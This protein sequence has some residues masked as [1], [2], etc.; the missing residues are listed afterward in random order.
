MLDNFFLT[1]LAT[2]LAGISSLS[3]QVQ[4]GASSSSWLSVDIIAAVQDTDIVGLLCLITLAIFSIASWGI[5]GYKLLHVNQATRQT[6]EFV[7]HCMEG[8]GNLEEAYKYAGNFP[9]SP[10]AQIM[11]D[12]Y[13][14]L[15][16]ENWYKDLIDLGTESR[17]MA[18]R[19]GAERVIERSIANEIKHL[20]GFLIFL[21]T[22]AAVCPF[23]GLFGT[24]WGVM[25]AFQE[26]ATSGAADITR[27]APG[28]S[29]ALTT[30]IAG[31]TAAIPAVISYNYLTTRVNG[32]LTRMDSFGLELMNI[33]QKQI[34]QK[35]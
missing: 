6:N 18:A 3:F 20:E 2:F 8:G 10:L 5:M 24:V 34:I 33:I 11:R 32:L 13:L 31:L 19:A 1:P 27:L 4:Q 28:I 12:V 25:A 23:I 21:A 16:V 30:T 35:I 15:Q 14:E 26:I 22:T 29:T 9:D 7:E 17:L